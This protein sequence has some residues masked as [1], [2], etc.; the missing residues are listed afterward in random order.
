MRN[1]R[2]QLLLASFLMLFVELVLIRWAGAYVVYLS[3]FSNFVLLGSFLG[4]G[5]GF[6]R[7]HKGA[8]PLHVGAVDP[9]AVFVGL[10]KVFPVADRSDG[11]RPRSTSARSRRTGLPIWVVL[12]FVFLGVAAIMTMI[13]Y[14]VAQRFRRFPALEAYRLDI[15]GSIAGHRR[16][17][18]RSRYFR[19][20]P[21]GWMLVIARR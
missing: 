4:I 20:P 5:L 14:G 16:R 1:D 13:A 21:I 11:R 17:S 15:L 9:L 7:A 2:I 3:Y 19:V 18:R 10:V 8:G 6:L 12:P